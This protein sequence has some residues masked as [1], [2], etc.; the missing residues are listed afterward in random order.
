MAD[1]EQ[2]DGQLS[3]QQQFDALSQA[4]M[5]L[6]NKIKGNPLFKLTPEWKE[7]KAIDEQLWDL[8][9]KMNRR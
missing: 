5:E 8:H 9:A 6:W 7:I 1:M 4:K 3:L 2:Q